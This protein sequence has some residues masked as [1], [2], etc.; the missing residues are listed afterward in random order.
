MTNT[1][2][3][4]DEAKRISDSDTDYRLAKTLNISTAEVSMFYSGKRFPNEYACMQIAKITGR[5]FEQV[6]A[7]VRIDA[8]KNENRRSEW[9]N[10]LKQMGGMAA[11]VTLSICAVV[12][13]NLTPTPANA[14]QTL[15]TAPLMICIMLNIA[16]MLQR[17]T[18]L[19]RVGFPSTFGMFVTRINQKPA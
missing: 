1:Q 9:K 13:L 5:N 12:I 14:A 8:E 19:R 4:L 16:V 11:S 7:M 6:T 10:R 15:E 2:A 17:Q 3:L 18:K